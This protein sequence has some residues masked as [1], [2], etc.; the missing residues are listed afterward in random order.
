M[1]TDIINKQ[2]AISTMDFLAYTMPLSMDAKQLRLQKKNSESPYDYV[3]ISALISYGNSLTK[4]VT[5]EQHPIFKPR[6]EWIKIGEN[7]IPTMHDNLI[8]PAEAIKM[9]WGSFAIRFNDD[10]TMIFTGVFNAMHQS[11]I[12]VEAVTPLQTF[13]RLKIVE[14]V[15]TINVLPVDEVLQVI[16]IPFIQGVDVYRLRAYNRNDDS[17]FTKMLKFNGQKYIMI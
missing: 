14:Y 2:V 17:I 9:I 6:A 16:A 4:H 5:L 1:I 10:R 7:T 3:D 15:T 12:N 8:V 11:E 13:T